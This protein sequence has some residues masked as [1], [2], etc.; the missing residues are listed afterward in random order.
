MKKTL[1]TRLLMIVLMIIIPLN[2]SARKKQNEALRYEIQ[3]AGV[4]TEGTYLVKA[5]VL[6]KKGNV[7]DELIKEAAIRGVIF[8]GFAA[9]QGSPAQKPMASAEV[10]QEKHVFFD[11]FFSSGAHLGYANIIPG[12]YERS[13]TASGDYRIGAT[14]QVQKTELRRHLEQAGIIRGLNTG[15]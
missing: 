7:P 5:Y 14:V 11:D 1:F 15:F 4:G 3:A 13:K 6:S 9:G 10:E 12:S 8:H 2:L